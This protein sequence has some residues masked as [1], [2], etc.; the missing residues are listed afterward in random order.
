MVPPTSEAE[1]PL[2]SALMPK[3]WALGGVVAPGEATLMS[4][5]LT[6]LAATFTTTGTVAGAL[7][8]PVLEVTVL[9]DGVEVLFPPPQAVSISETVITLKKPGLPENR[10]HLGG[11]S[12]DAGL[13]AGCCP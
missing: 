10:S 2:P 1:P 9:G 3:T 7:L 4:I 6:G 5:P 12:R 11:V 13:D 8:P